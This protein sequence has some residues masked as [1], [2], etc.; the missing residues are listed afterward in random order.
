[1]SVDDTGYCSK[2]ADGIHCTC[3]WDGDAC[4]A[5]NAPGMTNEERIRDGME[6]TE[7]GPPDIL[8]EVHGDK[9]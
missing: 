8:S 3:W 9:S 7:F 1:M 4:C 2:R 5:C 6:P